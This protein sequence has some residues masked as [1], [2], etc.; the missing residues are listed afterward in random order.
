MKYFIIFA[1]WAD[2]I[3]NVCVENSRKYDVVKQTNVYFFLIFCN[4]KHDEVLQ[5]NYKKNTWKSMKCHIFLFDSLSEQWWDQSVHQ[6]CSTTCNRS[7]SKLEKKKR[8]SGASSESF[9]KVFKVAYAR[10]SI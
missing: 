1:Y 4:G 2:H 6:L 8:F 9:E 3:H 10:Q 7:I 5:C